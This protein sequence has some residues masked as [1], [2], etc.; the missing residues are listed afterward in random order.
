MKTLCIII[1]M[2]LLAAGT[3]NS[4]AG[5]RK[6][7]REA[8]KLALSMP[9]LEYPLEAKQKHITGACIVLVEVSRDG[10]VL[11]ARMAK[12]SGSPILDHAAM[13]GCQRWRFRAGAAFEFLQPVSFSMA[14]A[15]TR[16]PR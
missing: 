12:S 15:F 9:G 7:F 6:T 16:F 8:E 5:A 10:H 1:A 14:G 13:N 3:G 2:A 11:S 4:R